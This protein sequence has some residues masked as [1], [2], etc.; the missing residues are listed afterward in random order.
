VT[1]VDKA[2]CRAQWHLDADHRWGV[3]AHA[4]IFQ[5]RRA[6]GQ[7]W[8]LE[9]DLQIHHKHIQLGV[10]ENRVTKYHDE[11]LFANLA[12][13]DFGL[14]EAQ[15]NAVLAGGLDL[16]AT[17]TRY[18]VRELF[19]TLIALQRPE[20]RA[21]KNV[22]ARDRSVYCS[23]LVQHLFRPVGLEL[24]PGIEAKNTT[25]EDLFRNPV[26][27]AAYLR[28]RELP[29]SAVQSLGRKMRHRLKA[30]VRMLKRKTRSA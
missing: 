11:T 23:A 10:Q 4:F 1:W 26:P 18:S 20:L 19:V 27:H 17:H 16:V 24:A 12:V 25:P 21:E 14:A 2:I 6:D 13:L 22:L 28:Q 8:V 5:G 30:R 15:I 29:R 3:W 7:H 9:S